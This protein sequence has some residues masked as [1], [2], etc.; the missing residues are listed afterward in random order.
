M[1]WPCR[2]DMWRGQLDAAKATHAA[3]VN[4][5]G[6]FEPV[7]LVADTGDGAE[8][9]AA[10]PERRGRRVAPGRLV[11][12]GHRGHRPDRRTAAGPA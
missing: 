10:C 3:V 6:R 12:P 2:D 8:A 9:A 5:I 11:G 7:L 1:A 4:A